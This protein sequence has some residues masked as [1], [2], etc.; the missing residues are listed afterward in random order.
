[1]V[2]IQLAFEEPGD[3]W[4][5]ESYTHKRGESQV[6]GWKLPDTWFR[7]GSDPVDREKGG[8][9]VLESGPRKNGILCLRFFTD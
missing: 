8:N 7:G 9:G 1:K 3:N 5:G 4:V 6:W 2:L